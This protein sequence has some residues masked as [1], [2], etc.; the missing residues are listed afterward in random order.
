M[1]QWVSD[2]MLQRR[3]STLLL[4]IFG[5]LALALALIGVYGVMSYTVAQR[6]AEIGLRMALGARPL[7]VVRMV[8]G[9]S[10][11]L[12]LAGFVLGVA[13]AFPLARLLASLL[14]GVTP[15]DPLTYAGVGALLVGVAALASWLPARRAARVDPLVALRAE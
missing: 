9:R 11:A 1:D 6:Q 8:V 4:A 10:V 12:A 5:G 3:L 14:F 15:A 2:S 13:L 7:D